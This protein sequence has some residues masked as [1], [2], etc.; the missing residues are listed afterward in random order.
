MLQSLKSLVRAWV[1]PASMDLSAFDEEWYL[2][3]YPDV[4]SRVRAGHIR[5]GRQHFIRH[6]FAE[7]R[8]GSPAGGIATTAQWWFDTFKVTPSG[9]VF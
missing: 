2:F 9:A 1:V 5:S 3:K 7:K 4:A 6:G 8:E